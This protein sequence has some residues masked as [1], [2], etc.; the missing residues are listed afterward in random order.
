MSK[1]RAWNSTLPAPEKPLDRSGPLPKRNAKRAKVRHAA[2]FGPPGYVEHVHSF[3]CVFAVERGTTAE[4]EGPLEACH[5]KS[6]GA[7][8]G[9]RKNLFCACRKHHAMQHA[10]GVAAFER[11]VPTDL[12]LW[13]CAITGKWDANQR[14]DFDK[15]SA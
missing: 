8:G 7:G 1:P 2:H 13:A 9:W 12:D 5:R 6:R 14:D 11:F 15:E 4:C 10:M 3:G